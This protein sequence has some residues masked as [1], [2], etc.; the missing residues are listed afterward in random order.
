MGRLSVGMDLVSFREVEEALASF[1]DRY[2]R[3]VFTDQELSESRGDARD[4]AGR[5]AAKEAAIKALTPE[6][7]DVVP[8]RSV[9]VLSRRP[10]GPSITLTGKAME[11]SRRRGISQLRLGL[12]RTGEG[13]GA[14]V[15]GHGPRANRPE[16][17]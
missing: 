8:W 1:G 15:I 10:G 16:H 5:F 9:G 4:L 13:A 14:V 6:V 12:S 2:L 3:R 7:E 11:L 17:S